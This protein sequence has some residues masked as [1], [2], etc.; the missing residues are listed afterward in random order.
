MSSDA[1]PKHPAQNRR[2]AGAAMGDENGPSIRRIPLTTIGLC[3]LGMILVGSGMRHAVTEGWRVWLALAGML[4]VILVMAMV[5]ERWLTRER[6]RLIASA[7]KW[8]RVSRDSGRGKGKTRRRTGGR[9]GEKPVDG[10]QGKLRLPSADEGVA[11]PGPPH[12]GDPETAPSEVP[13]EATQ[14]KEGY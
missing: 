13:P 6:H 10:R 5:Q 14:R 4:I 3:G 9:N 2:A 11:P 12:T 1:D 8:T 7:L